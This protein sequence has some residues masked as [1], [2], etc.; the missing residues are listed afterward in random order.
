MAGME[1]T[2]RSH[3]MHK[4]LRM[5]KKCKNKLSNLTYNEDCFGR[6]TLTKQNRANGAASADK[7]KVYEVDSTKNMIQIDT[8]LKM[9]LRVG[10]LQSAFLLFLILFLF[11]QISHF[12]S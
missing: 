12:F 9:E 5:R 11:N 6:F 4:V 8:W 10:I 1:K 3:F 2:T 7:L